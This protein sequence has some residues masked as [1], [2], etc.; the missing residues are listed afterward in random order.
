VADRP[1]R[2]HPKV[3]R[4]VAAQARKKRRQPAVARHP[5][6]RT[7]PGKRPR[8]P[9]VRRRRAVLGTTLGVLA[10]IGVLFGFVYPTSTFFRQRSEM[11]QAEDRLQRLENETRRLEKEGTKLEGDAEVERLAR[12]QYG[13]VRPGET[14][15]VIVPESTTTTVPA[16][17]ESPQP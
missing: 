9:R 10:V 14:P 2:A 1:T 15:Y 17:G 7:P 12:E 3:P 13:L 11:N 8:S 16:G 6:S 5:A 4:K